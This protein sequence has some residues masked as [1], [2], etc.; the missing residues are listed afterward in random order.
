MEVNEAAV[1]MEPT[2]EELL[3]RIAELEAKTRGTG[4]RVGVYN[5]SAKVTT[6]GGLSVY[7]LGRFPVTLYAEQWE[8]LSEF[9]RAGHLNKALETNAGNLVRKD[10]LVAA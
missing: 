3:A 10:R 8:A 4:T 1:A 9:V 7:G 5:I 6:K 2:R